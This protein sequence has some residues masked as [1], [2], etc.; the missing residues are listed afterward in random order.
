[1]HFPLFS[2][3]FRCKERTCSSF[4]FHIYIHVHI[5]SF[6]IIQHACSKILYEKFSLKETYKFKAYTF[7]WVTLPFIELLCIYVKK[8]TSYFDPDM[9]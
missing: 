4:F 5:L 8:I 3:R 1:M 7:L 9:I 6:C 2:F